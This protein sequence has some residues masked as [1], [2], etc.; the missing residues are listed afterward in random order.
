[1]T[2][3]KL[4]EMNFE[5]VIKALNRVSYFGMRYK[6]T[7]EVAIVS[8]KSGFNYVKDQLMTRYGDVEVELHPEERILLNQI[9]IKDEKFQKD[10]DKFYKDKSEWCKKYGCD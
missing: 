1:M 4:S 7:D 10:L 2:K 9:V 6:P 8:D 3:M 5:S